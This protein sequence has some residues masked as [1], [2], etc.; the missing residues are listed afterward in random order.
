MDEIGPMTHKGSEETQASMSELYGSLASARESMIND[1]ASKANNPT[2]AQNLLDA[3]ARYSKYIRILPDIARAAGKEV[4]HQVS[5]IGTL[6]NAMDA[7]VNKTL[8]A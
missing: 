7:M 4:T 2:L 8:T 1:I 6:K 3:N 5:S